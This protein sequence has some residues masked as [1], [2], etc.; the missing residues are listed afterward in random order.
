MMRSLKAVAC[1]C[2]LMLAPGC[3]VIE[4]VASII[5]GRPADL[6]ALDALEGA[7]LDVQAFVVVATWAAL[8]EQAARVLESGLAPES[9]KLAI[10][11]T[12]VATAPLV[13]A[14]SEIAEAYGSARV[15]GANPSTAV[16]PMLLSAMTQ[17]VVVATS[18]LQTLVSLHPD[19]DTAGAAQ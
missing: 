12:S 9:L 18:R 10:Q 1:A 8:Q 7:T 16:D 19:T 4:D 14:L 2:C 15:A 5:T 17:E 6:P 11:E 3:S 13:V